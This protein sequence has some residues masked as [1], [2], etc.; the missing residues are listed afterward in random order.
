MKTLI[1]SNF[2][3]LNTNKSWNK[4]KKLKI[5]FSE[6]NQIQFDLNNSK[7]INDSDIFVGIVYLNTINQSQVSLL[8]NLISSSSQKFYKTK[9]I[10]KFLTQ[11]PY[12]I[13]ILFHIGGLRRLN[14]S[15]FKEIFSRYTF[16]IVRS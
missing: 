4:L 9:F 8:K 16:N 10:F 12:F 13:P 5:K 1:T 14:F 2:N 11:I 15:A 3:L 6:Y 7:K